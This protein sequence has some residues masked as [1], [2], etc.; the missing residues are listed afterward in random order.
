MLERETDTQTERVKDL[1]PTASLPRCPPRTRAGLHCSWEMETQGRSPM[2]EAGPNYLGH[3]WL[4][5]R[6]HISRKLRSRMEPGAW[7]GVLYCGL[8]VSQETSSLVCQKPVHHIPEFETDIFLVTYLQNT[9][10]FLLRFHKTQFLRQLDFWSLRLPHP[11][12]TRYLTSWKTCRC[13]RYEL[14]KELKK[15]STAWSSMQARFR[16]GWFLTQ[17]VS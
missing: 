13:A 3:H 17:P 16:H 12:R 8:W 11:S 5:P 2:W 1:L 7:L 15:L 14:Q 10:A 9:L 4:L 6:L